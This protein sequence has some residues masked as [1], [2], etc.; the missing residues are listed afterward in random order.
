MSNYEETGVNRQTQRQQQQL[1]NDN[2]NCSE[3][4]ETR[5]LRR[6]GRNIKE[7][8][9]VIKRPSALIKSPYVADD[10]Q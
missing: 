7:D 2:V 10:V 5:K 6:S 8:I 3:I 1:N 4:G 9:N